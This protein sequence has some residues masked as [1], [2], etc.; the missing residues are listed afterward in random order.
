[1]GTLARKMG[2]AMWNMECKSQLTWPISVVGFQHS[3][4][5]SNRSSHCTK[6]KSSV[7]DFSKKCE[8]I[9]SFLRICSR[10]LKKSLSE[11]LILYADS[12][13]NKKTWWII[14]CLEFFKKDSSEC[15]S[16]T[17][18]EIF[19][20]CNLQFQEF[21]EFLKVKFL[22]VKFYMLPPEYDVISKD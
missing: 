2:R 1:M 11:N 20:N 18:S 5:V 17:L 9:R 14:V 15:S 13:N 3:Q 6:I 8:Q 16:F 12:N 7:N 22:K 4:L 10:L 19:K 21:F